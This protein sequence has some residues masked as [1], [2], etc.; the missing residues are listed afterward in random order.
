MSSNPAAGD[1]L[2]PIPEDVMS[3]SE[4]RMRQRKAFRD[5]TKERI[6]NKDYRNLD[7]P[8]RRRARAARVMGD[9][10]AA[11]EATR[12]KGPALESLGPA[13]DVPGVLLERIINGENFLGVR[14]LA[15]GQRAARAIA[16][17]DIRTPDGRSGSGTGSLVSSR[18]LLTNNHVLQSPDW[19]RR[20]NAVFDFEDDL[21]NKPRPTVAFELD[22]DAF[23]FTN[24]N[25]DFTLVAVKPTALHTGVSLSDYG[26]NPLDDTQGKVTIGEPI[27]IIQHPSGLL[28]QVVLQENRLLDIPEDPPGW[29][30]YESDT[31][32]GS[33]GAP[34]FNNRWEMV[35][36]HHSGWPKRDEQ[37]RILTVNNELWSREMG[38]LAIKWLGNEG[39]RVSQILLIVKQEQAAM[40]AARQALINE[41]LN[42]PKTGSVVV[43]PAGNTPIVVSGSA[44]ES[45]S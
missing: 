30:H 7:T 18:L 5:A 12:V 10:V 27:N 39:A 11:P 32:P 1:S 36:L 3:E 14:F 19:A 16:R 40:D 6:K 34:L 17:I 23:F 9:P 13:D 42:P 29:L 38:E 8:A 31:M 22:P 20:S 24:K 43:P 15:L 45:V 41:L 21:D 33:S 2:S 37:G 28:K 26:F 44:S 25:F 35:G 4:A